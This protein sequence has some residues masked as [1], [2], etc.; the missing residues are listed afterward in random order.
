MKVETPLRTFVVAA[1]IA[2]SCSVLVASAVYVLRPLQKNDQVLER[3][4]VILDAAG[5]SLA[6]VTSDADLLSA[7]MGLDA[8]VVKLGSPELL[9]SSDA[10]V[11][12]H[13]QALDSEEPAAASESRAPIYLVRQ[14]G[15]LKRI[16]FPV[17]GAGMWSTIY[18]YLALGPDLTTI[19]DLVFLRHGETPG[20]GDRIEDPAWRREWQGKK[21]FDENGKPRLRVVRDARNEY[22]VDLISGASVTCEAVGELVVAAFDDDG[23]GPLVQRLRREGAN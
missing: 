23:Y 17:H 3:G 2:L 10:H 4:R 18:G 19:V 13:W 1:C 11:Y 14:E 6:G 9:G 15:T 20:V 5:E 7:Y 22:E 12:D 8:R 21:L 16:V